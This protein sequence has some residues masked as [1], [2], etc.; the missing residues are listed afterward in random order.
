MFASQT[1]IVYI[2]IIYD[3]YNEICLLVYHMLIGFI[4]D[5]HDPSKT[6]HKTIYE[7]HDRT[8]WHIYIMI[9]IVTFLLVTSTL[10]LPSIPVLAAK[11]IHILVA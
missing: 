5:I 9:F 6:W 11:Q 7:E 3:M 8:N 1:L 4:Y 2:V 10:S